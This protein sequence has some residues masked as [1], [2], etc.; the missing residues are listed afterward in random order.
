MS[1]SGGSHKEEDMRDAKVWAWVALGVGAGV[2][3]AIAVGWGMRLADLKRR[4]KLDPRAAKV[5][6]LILEAEKLLAQGRR[7]R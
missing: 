6:E 4:K 5:Q 3:I 1:R 7:S 2:A